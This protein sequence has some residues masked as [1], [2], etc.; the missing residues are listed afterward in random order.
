MTEKAERTFRAKDRLTKQAPD[1][2]DPGKSAS[3]KTYL[4]VPRGI[5]KQ[6]KRRCSQTEK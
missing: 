1:W 2:K 3:E 5:P 4:P 6:K